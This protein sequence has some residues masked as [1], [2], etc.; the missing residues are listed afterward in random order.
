MDNNGTC[1][2]EV[3]TGEL[4]QK[5]TAHYVLGGRGAIRIGDVYFSDGKRDGRLISKLNERNRDKIEEAVWHR[6]QRAGSD[7]AIA[8]DWRMS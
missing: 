3:S 5:V 4:F 8:A 6:L 2:V 1:T 7:E